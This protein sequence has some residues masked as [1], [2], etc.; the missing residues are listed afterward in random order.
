MDSWLNSVQNVFTWL[1]GKKT[2]V[3]VVTLSL[4]GIG[5]AE[6]YIDLPAWIFL[7]LGGLTVV[8]LRSAIVP[9]GAKK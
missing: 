4:L 7:V 6:G 9:T 5:Q 3:S 2:I 1:K 8:F